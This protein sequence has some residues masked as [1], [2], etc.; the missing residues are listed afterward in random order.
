VAAIP[1]SNLANRLESIVGAGHVRTPTNREARAAD[2]IVEPAS[3]EEICEIVRMCEADRIALAAIGASRSL[4][5]IRRSPVALGIS[6]ARLARIIAYE[7]DDMTVV[8]ESGITVGALNEAMAHSGQ[9]LP[10]DPFDPAMTTLG[11]LIGASHAGPLRQIGR[12]HV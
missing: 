11:S 9:R 3:V 2:T 12:A 1:P 8:A 4:A 7:P 10:L 5:G 6:M